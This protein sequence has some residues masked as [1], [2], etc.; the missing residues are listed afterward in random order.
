MLSLGVLSSSPSK[1]L[2]LA[3]QEGMKG[4]IKKDSNL[5]KLD[6]MWITTS[7]LCKIKCTFE[8]P[9]FLFPKI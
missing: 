1:K 2:I 7:V 6:M 9:Y 4:S 3:L 8:N 5:M